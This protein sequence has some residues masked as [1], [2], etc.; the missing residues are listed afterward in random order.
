[1]KKENYM[2]N[3]QNKTMKVNQWANAIEKQLSGL[4]LPSTINLLRNLRQII[5]KNPAIPYVFQS[6]YQGVTLWCYSIVIKQS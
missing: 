2:Y 3:K 4:T 6:L 5:F 1:M